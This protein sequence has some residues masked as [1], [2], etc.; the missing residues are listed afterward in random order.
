M[1]IGQTICAEDVTGE[2]YWTPWF[3]RQ[4]DA[5]TSVVETI[6]IAGST[7]L[8]VTLFHKDPNDT[9]D[10]TANGSAASITTATTTPFR[11]TG[12]KALVRYKLLYKRDSGTGTVFCHLRFL[13]P[14]WEATGA[15]S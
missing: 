5:C 11:R 8:E 10:G 13:N 3:P 12:C 1:I 15:Q 14:S 2:T 6:C 9:G 7:T 4:G